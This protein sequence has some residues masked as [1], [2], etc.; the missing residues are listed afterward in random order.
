MEHSL[1]DSLQ[2]KLSNRQ[3][4]NNLRSLV[5]NTSHIDFS[6]N[7]Y[8]GLARSQA[9][10]EKI[11]QH[12]EQYPYNGATGSR[13]ISGNSQ[14]V[15]EAEEKLSKL[16]QSEAC[17]IVNSGYMANLTV[18]S[19]VPQRNDTILYDEL[20]HACIKD[21]ARLSMA[22]R[23][24]FKHN[25]LDDLE[26]KLKKSSGTKFVVVESVYSMDGDLCPLEELTFLTEKYNAILIV[27]EAHST[28]LFTET[29]AG[30]VVSKK[31]ASKIPIRIYT[32]GKAMGIHGACICTSTAVKNYLINFSRPFIYT[33]AL[34]PHSISSIVCAF[35]YLHENKTLQKALSNQINY[36]KNHLATESKTP[37]QPIIIPGNER[38]K[39]IAGILHKEGIFVKP[40][41]SPTVKEGSERL[42]I[43]LHS[44]NTQTEIDSLIC[45]LKEFI[46]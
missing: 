36:F 26:S 31:L 44:F 4:S 43:C 2:K 40:I 45:S 10:F 21:G 27:D 41:L 22:S 7:D 37:I 1:E 17:L 8:L 9:L 3:A 28:G 39:E 5:V 16:F 13:L 38:V 24:P 23:H 6:S 34:P 11:K 30:Y 33:T 42:R 18:L 19:S 14:Q 46:H 12:T 32:F 29:G 35:D 25:D 20:A 15:V